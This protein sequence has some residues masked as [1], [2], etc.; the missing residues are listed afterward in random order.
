MSLVLAQHRPLM[1][2]PHIALVLEPRIGLL[3][4]EPRIA[5]LVLRPF[6]R[7]ALAPHIA[8]VLEPRIGR[9]PRQV[10]AQHRS[11]L[12]QRKWLALRTSSRAPRN[13]LT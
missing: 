6:Q 4:L 2:A 1:L 3:V 10:L 9:F 8:L 11:L 13:C 7:Q 5:L 12:A